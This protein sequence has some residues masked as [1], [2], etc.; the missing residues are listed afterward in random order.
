MNES[1]IQAS[2]YISKQTA[3]A[4]IGTLKKKKLSF[5]MTPHPQETYQLVLK[6]LDKYDEPLI[7]FEQI[8]KGPCQ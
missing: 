5:Q 1:G 6:D 3:L 2:S 8:K 4:L 7:E